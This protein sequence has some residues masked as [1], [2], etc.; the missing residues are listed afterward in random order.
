[1]SN[2]K[3]RNFASSDEFVDYQVLN[4][5]RKQHEFE[6]ALQ[7]LEYLIT[8]CLEKLIRIEERLERMEE[9]I[10]ELSA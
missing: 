7:S 1:M 5:E 2:E 6:N 9:V 4:E 10:E 3:F 8:N